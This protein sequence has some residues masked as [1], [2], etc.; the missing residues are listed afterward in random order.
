MSLFVRRTS[1]PPTEERS[2]VQIPPY[3]MQPF[4]A[5]VFVDEDTALRH[6][7]VWSCTTKIA[8]DVAMMPV[9]VVR[10]QNG[11]RV[12]VDPA[13]QI[14]SAP[15]VL[16]SDPMD[17]RQDVL[18]SWLRWG[19]AWGL[20]TQISA[21][22]LY[23]TRIELVNPADVYVWDD[24]KS[25]RFRVNGEEHALWPVG[26][27]WHAP[28]YTVPGQLLGLSPIRYHAASIRTGLLA[29][30][31]GEQFFTGGGHPSGL[32]SPATDPGKEGAQA[33][34]ESFVNAT[35][36]RE[37]AVIPQSVT[38]T[39]IQV[40]PDDSQFLD[41]MRY[42]VEQVCR[43]FGEDP[44]DH[45]SSG[46]GSSLTYANRSDA[47][48]ARLKRRQFWVVKLQNVL[49]AMVPPGLHARLNT[50][51][52][53]MMTTMERHQLHALRLNSGTTT[54]D[55][56]RQIEDEAPID[57]KDARAWQEVGLPALVAGG[58]LTV[59]EARKELGLAPMP[60]GDDLVSPDPSPQEGTP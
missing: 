21:N 51:A 54:V 57:T 30:Q 26:D 48:L 42:S 13:P 34:K 3:A 6:D 53:L 49:T 16:R 17:W 11:R 15:S 10:Y 28:A 9:D 18:S 14:I 29:G 2:T 43:I 31:F 19:N 27:L 40:N 56:I 20:V 24:A 33:L 45:G 47:D 36:G 37:P 8:Q 1:E 35:R 7:A 50:S 5:S 38:Y 44:A 32:L 25:V 4:V 55:E 41:T 22:G 12:P 23:P 52:S 60:G 59:N 46:G 39:P 58:V